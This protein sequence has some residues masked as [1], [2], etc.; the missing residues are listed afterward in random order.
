MLA[1]AME[2][3]ARNELLEAEAIRVLRLAFRVGDTEAQQLLGE[4]TQ[5]ILIRTKT[6]YAFQMRSYG[7][8]LAAAELADVRERDRVWAISSIRQVARQV[9]FQ[10]ASSI[11]IF[12]C[13]FC[14]F[15]SIGLRQSPQ[16]R[17]RAV[18]VL[19]WNRHTQCRLS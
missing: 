2:I 19:A 14:A 11:V 13:G 8:Y 12:F 9:D 15:L 6:G 18:L 1:L 3:A 16:R 5:S 10:G 17:V 4:L 7:E